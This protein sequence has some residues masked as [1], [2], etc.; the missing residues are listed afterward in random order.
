V[1]ETIDRLEDLLRSKGIKIF[2]RLDQ[3]AEVQA[4]S[5]SLDFLLSAKRDAAAAERFL[6]KALGKANHPTPRVI[7]TDKHA[8]LL[9]RPEADGRR[10]ERQRRNLSCWGR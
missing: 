10:S 7:N 6:A 8:A 1:P 9:S 4:V 2:A 3:A 5:F